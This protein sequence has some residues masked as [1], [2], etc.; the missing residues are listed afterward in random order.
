MADD[1]LIT[2]K[3]WKTKTTIVS[4]GFKDSFFSGNLTRIRVD[5]RKYNPYILLEFLQS[6]TGKRML[7]S[8]QTGTTITLI[9]NKQLSRMEVSVYSKLVMDDIGQSIEENQKTYKKRVKEAEEEY[10]EKRA[11][12]IKK[13][14]LNN[15]L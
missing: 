8:I 4:T 10:K 9:N 5:R 12:L 6:E 1:I 11:K 3:G 13:L 7:Q 15:S 2:T 14:G